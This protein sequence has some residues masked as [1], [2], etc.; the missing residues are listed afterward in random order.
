MCLNTDK[1]AEPMIWRESFT[2]V[3]PSLAPLMWLW[4]LS[5]TKVAFIRK[6]YITLFSWIMKLVSWVGVS[7]RKLAKNTGLV[8]IHGGL[9][10]ESLAFSALK[11]TRTIWA[12]KRHVCGLCQGQAARPCFLIFFSPFHPNKISH[13]FRFLF[14]CLR[15]IAFIC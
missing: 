11:C 9:I 1:S 10:G 7:T 2:N 8:G 15:T 4:N 3:D 13:F 12:S 14:C 6:S 5:T